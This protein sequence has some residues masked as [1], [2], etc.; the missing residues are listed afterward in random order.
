MVPWQWGAWLTCQGTVRLHPRSDEKDIQCVSLSKKYPKRQNRFVNN[1]LWYRGSMDV[2][3]D[4]IR[5]AGLEG[6][7][8]VRQPAYGGWGFQCH[9]DRSVGF[10]VVVQGSC[11]LRS[12]C[13]EAPK[14]LERGDVV[15]IA[16]GMP[17][18]LA[19]APEHPADSA[20]AFRARPAGDGPPN[21]TLACAHFRFREEPTHPFFAELPP[22]F[23][24]AGAMLPAHHGIH[25]VVALLSSEL[26]QAHPGADAVV[27]RLVDVLFHYIVRA[28]IEQKHATPGSWAAALRDES[29]ARALAAMHRD[30]GR[31]WEVAALAAECGLSRSAF[32]DRFKRTTGE[33]PAHYL[34]RLRVQR[35]M[36][37]LR[38]TDDGLDS[39]ASAVGYA[40]AFA[41]SKAFKREVGIS[42][43]A[44][45]KS[46]D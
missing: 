43:G 29:L 13:L 12:P 28:W 42:P 22:I 15:F 2:L 16:R 44:Y 6:R 31:D 9:C 40:N 38:T 36:S 45:R 10:H 1:A 14:R 32:A 34:A 26:D 39:V 17:H 46:L 37:L 19:S 11:W 41:F 25:T 5:M 30:V 27:E 3:T 35:A 18:E 8:F 33:T 4:L 7:L 23:H 24:L 21:A 20:E